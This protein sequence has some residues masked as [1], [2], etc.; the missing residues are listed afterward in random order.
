MFKSI[1]LIQENYNYLLLHFKKNLRNNNFYHY[2][3]IL[4][5]T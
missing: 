2:I 5:I 1:F 4:I 3:I